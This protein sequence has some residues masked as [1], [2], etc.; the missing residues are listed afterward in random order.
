M[1]AEEEEEEGDEEDAGSFFGGGG[2]GGDGGW[3][4]WLQD[5]PFEFV[6][7]IAS[8]RAMAKSS[9]VE[10]GRRTTHCRVKVTVMRSRDNV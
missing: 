6:G 9:H 8:T 10:C 2:G 1:D 7:E 4:S 5:V 3:R